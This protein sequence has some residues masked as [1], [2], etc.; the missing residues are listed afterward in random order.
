MAFSLQT[1]KLVE[2]SEP[3]TYRQA[4]AASDKHQWVAAIKLELERFEEL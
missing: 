2:Y 4:I 1:K 3:T